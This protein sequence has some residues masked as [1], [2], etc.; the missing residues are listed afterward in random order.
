MKIIIKIYKIYQEIIVKENEKILII[1]PHPDDE[2]I[3][4]GG[5]L[6][7]YGTQCDVWVISDGVAGKSVEDNRDIISVRK[8]EFQHE[9]QFYHVNSYK[10]F[11]LPD[12]HLSE[13]EDYMRIL[14]I[15]QY[16]KIFVVNGDDI[17][18]DHRAVY[19]MLIKALGR[20]HSVNSLEVYQYEV[21]YPLKRVTHYF[22]ISKYVEKKTLGIMYHKSQLSIFDYIRPSI[23]L[24][25]YRAGFVNG[26]CEYV[27]AFCAVDI[28][29]AKTEESV[30]DENK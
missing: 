30:V 19:R 26:N 21:T 11:D 13:Y 24:N 1:S 10:M 6:S 25:N 23:A 18:V 22:D 9:M 17:S 7:H 27:E 15:G 14:D 20:Y 8:V 16:N 4:M 12:G 28:H 29:N 5:F 2:C 3:G